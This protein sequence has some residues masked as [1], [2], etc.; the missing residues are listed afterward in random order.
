[1]ASSHEIPITIKLDGNNYSHWSMLFRNF[2]KGKGL[3]NYVT[4]KERCPDETDAKFADW[5]INNNKILTWIANTVIPS[6]SI[7]LGKY[8]TAQK[9]WDFLAHRYIQSNFAKKYKLEQDIQALQ[10]QPGQ[11]VSDFHSSMCVIWDQ[12]ELMEPQW[13][14][15][16]S[17]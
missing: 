5:D 12:L 10:Q 2:L 16:L 13:T 8:D 14:T 3:W 4:E 17:I 15:Y 1:M 11:S 7:Q 9:A 6:I